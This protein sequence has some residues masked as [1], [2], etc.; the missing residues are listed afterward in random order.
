M[1]TN[2]SMMT[3]GRYLNKKK[4]WPVTKI[5]FFG[6]CGNWIWKCKGWQISVEPPEDYWHA[7]QQI[8]TV[9]NVALWFKCLAWK[10]GWSKFLTHLKSGQTEGITSS[11]SMYACECE[12][13]FHPLEKCAEQNYLS[14]RKPSVRWWTV[15]TEHVTETQRG[16]VWLTGLLTVWVCEG[17]A[18]MTPLPWQVRSVG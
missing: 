4:N 9:W 7:L 6:I 12:P 13:S 10:G 18:W 2:P 11:W 1:H 5:I 16:S 15:L 8:H 17:D 14:N 3:L